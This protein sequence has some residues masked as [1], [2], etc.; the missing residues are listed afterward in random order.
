[1]HPKPYLIL[2]FGFEAFS[3]PRICWVGRHFFDHSIIA[4][5]VS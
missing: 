4:I 3:A 1:M 5:S 2:C